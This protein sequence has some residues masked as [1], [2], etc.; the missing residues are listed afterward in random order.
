MAGNDCF[1]GATLAVVEGFLQS[2]FDFK[3]WI[4]S[5]LAFTSCS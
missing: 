2:T 5:L 4:G 1:I 3:S